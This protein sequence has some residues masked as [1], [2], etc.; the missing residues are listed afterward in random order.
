MYVNQ[1]YFFFIIIYYVLWSYKNIPVVIAG[2]HSCS[3]VAPH[4]K[5][6]VGTGAPVVTLFGLLFKSELFRFLRT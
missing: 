3:P 4:K 6:F 2:V 1:K 5:L